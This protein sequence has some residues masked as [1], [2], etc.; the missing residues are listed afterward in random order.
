MK[1]TLSVEEMK[2]LFSN[3]DP[4][5]SLNPEPYFLDTDTELDTDPMTE[6]EQENSNLPETEAEYLQIRIEELTSERE[7]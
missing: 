3:N 6:I 1:M 2:Q 7:A 5:S 4:K